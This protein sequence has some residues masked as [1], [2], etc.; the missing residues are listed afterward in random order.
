M[1][2]TIYINERSTLK[3]IKKEFRKYLMTGGSVIR[4]DPDL[5]TSSIDS[6]FK[7][8][9]EFYK[10]CEKNNISYMILSE[11]L[12]LKGLDENINHLITESIEKA[13][14]LDKPKLAKSN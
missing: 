1:I 13:A 14:S 8:Y 4:I 12:K 3:E 9:N 11:L 2:H 6:I 7:I 5:K 10:S